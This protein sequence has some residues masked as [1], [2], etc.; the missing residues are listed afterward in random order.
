MMWTA[1][2]YEALP[3]LMEKYP[4]SRF[5]MLTL[6][7]KNVEIDSLRSS[8]DEMGKA[9]H[10][11]I[12]RDEFK[13][14]LGW[15][16]T[17]EI[18]RG[19]D[20]SAHPHFHVL[21]MVGPSYFGRSYVTQARWTELWQECGKLDYQPIVDIRKVKSRKTEGE[22]DPVPSGVIE[23]LKYAVK[24][25]DLAVEADSEAGDW[26]RELARQIHRTR[27]IATGGCLKDFF[28]EPSTDEEMIHTKEK[29]DDGDGV[30][31]DEPPATVDF[32]YSTQVKRY[33]RRRT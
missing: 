2:M 23:V 30:D 9:W 33:R 15:V 25:S 11:L 4:K 7:V 22:A 20:G 16:R 8:L 19:K 5:L 27:A 18:T 32:T 14:V 10:R 1:R 12:K 28:K 6:T 24:P 21:L 13:P 26:V 3:T 29:D 31:E 17:V